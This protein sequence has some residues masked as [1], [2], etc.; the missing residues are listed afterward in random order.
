MNSY[1]TKAVNKYIYLLPISCKI[2][3]TKI[4][5]THSVSI[6][7]FLSSITVR[8]DFETPQHPHTNFVKSI[9]L[10]K[11]SNVH[12]NVIQ[13][14]TNQIPAQIFESLQNWKKEASSSLQTLKRSSQT[15]DQT[16]GIKQTRSP[17]QT[18]RVGDTKEKQA[19]RFSPE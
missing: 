4:I 15:N 3:S 12:T 10:S 11:F 13:R 17:S 2:C 5:K 18:I 14:P 1:L 6:L 8:R 16:R 7:N 9:V 19:Y